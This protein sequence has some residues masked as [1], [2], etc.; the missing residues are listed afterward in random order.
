MSIRDNN[1]NEEL[2]YENRQKWFRYHMHNSKVSEENAWKQINEMI[3]ISYKEYLDK[4]KDRLG[5]DPFKRII[6]KIY[7]ENQDMFKI[8]WIESE[9]GILL[10]DYNSTIGLIYRNL[11]ETNLYLIESRDQKLKFTNPDTE[12]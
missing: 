7:Y 11:D 10:P 4:N 12:K 8:N 6:E 1:N 2:T 3:R 5:N 9:N